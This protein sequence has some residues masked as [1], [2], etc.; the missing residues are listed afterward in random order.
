M[1]EDVVETEPVKKSAKKK[2][3]EAT[4]T[5]SLETFFADDKHEIIP[6]EKIANIG[7]INERT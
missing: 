2:K 3:F 1:K 7:D 5:R 4:S 6:K